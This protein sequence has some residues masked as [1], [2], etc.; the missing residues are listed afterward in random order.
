MNM[1]H[2][3]NFSDI[4]PTVKS[5]LSLENDFS[6]PKLLKVVISA[7]CGKYLKDPNKIDFIFDQIMKITGQLPV[8]AKAK[9]SVAGFSVRE[10]MI[11]GV[12]VTL[13]KASMYE[14]VRRLAYLALP[15]VRDFHGMSLNAFDGNGNYN[16]G[17]KDHTVFFES[18]S[19]FSFGLNIALI[20]SASSDADCEVLL[21]NLWLPFREKVHNV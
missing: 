13:R 12:F 21:K 3:E 16:L 8:K 1:K 17:I 7:G 10:G 2:Y 6:V 4:M 15:R 19:T 5:Q 20:T 9:K 14:F 11:S 18:D